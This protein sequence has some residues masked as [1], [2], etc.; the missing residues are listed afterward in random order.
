MELLHVHVYVYSIDL[1]L[2]KNKEYNFVLIY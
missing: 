1:F 2:K